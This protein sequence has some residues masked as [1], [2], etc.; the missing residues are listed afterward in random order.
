MPSNKPIITDELL[1]QHRGL[2]GS[3]V[4]SYSGKGLSDDDL[5][6][7]GMIGLMK[8]AYSYDPDK[9]TQFSSYAV[10]WIKKYILVALTR[11]QRTSLGAVEL[12][13]KII[14]TSS[15]PAITQDKQQLL[16]PS[17]FPPLEAEI[18]KLSLEQQLSLKQIS[19]ILDI[20]VER[21]K[22]LKLKALRRFKVWKTE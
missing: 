5:F 4:K 17:S 9:G 21:C 18:L 16:I 2:V 12:T 6:Q 15:A 10:Y 13:E 20:S 19:Q 11:E 7:E 22:Q 14:S 8:A 3:I 1:N